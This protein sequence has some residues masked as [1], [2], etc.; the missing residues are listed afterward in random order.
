MRNFKENSGKSYHVD[1]ALNYF[2]K[3]QYIYKM[4]KQYVTI[5]VLAKCNNIV[6]YSVEH[7]ERNTLLYDV[8]Y[9]YTLYIT[10]SETHIQS[11]GH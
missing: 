2:T 3:E 11:L 8:I 6:V 1:G 5:K 4:T 7:K 10:Q 9:L